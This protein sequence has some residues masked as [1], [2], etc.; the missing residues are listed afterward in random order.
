MK[1]NA[2]KLGVPFFVPPP[3]IILVMKITTFFILLAIMSASAGIKAQSI[4]LSERN[5]SLQRVLEKIRIQSGYDLVGDSKLIKAGKPVSI[6]LKNGNLQDALKL[7]FSNQEL[8]FEIENKTILVKGKESSFWEEIVARL[9]LIDI[10]SRI[11][12]DKGTVLPGATV[13]IKGTGRVTTTD[14]DGTFTLKGVD[15]H[16]ILSISFI[17]FTTLEIEAGKINGPVTLQYMVSKLDEVTVTTAYGIE[18]SKKELGYS[19]AKVSGADITKANSGSILMGLE[20]KVS[21]MNIMAQSSEMSPKMKILLRGIRSFGSSS[22]NQPLFIFNGAPLSFGSDGDAGEQALDFINNLNPADVEDVT[23]LKGANGA[24]MYGPEGVNGVIIITTK[25]VKQG[26]MSVNARVNT[27]YNRLDWRPRAEQHTFGVGDG[28]GNLGGRALDNWGPAYD[29]KL[30]SIGYP[31]KNGLYQQVPYTDRDDRHKFFNVGTTTRSNVSLAQG[32]PTGSYY[33]GLGYTTQTGL[34][35]GDKQD[36]VNVLYN[37][38]KRFGKIADVQLN[39]NF[40]KSSSDKGTDVTAAVVNMPSFIPLLSY[41][42]YQNSYWG[43]TDNYW[44]GRNPYAALGMERTIGRNIAFNGSLIATLKPTSWFNIKDQVSMLYAERNSKTN[45][46]PVVFSDFARVDPLKAYDIQPGTSDSFIAGT[47]VNNDILL[48]SVNKAG[49]FLIRGT[50]GNTIRN[51][52]TKQ[53]LTAAN[54]IIPVYNDIFA[55]KDEGVA[56]QEADVMQRTIS[57]FGNISVGYKDKIFLEVTGRDEWDS[58]RAKV[59]RGKDLYFGANSSFVMKELVPYLKDLDWLSNFRLRLSATKTAN[60]NIAPQQSELI[61]NLA[62]GYPYTNPTTG[63]SVLGYAVQV[64]PNP[65]LKPEKVFS[66]EY[67]TEIGLFNNRI[68]FDA[69]YYHQVNDGV[70]MEVG[71]PEWSAYPDIDNAGRFQNSGWEFDLNLS[72]LIDFGN[73]I[74]INLIG[75]LSINNNKVLQVSDIYNGTFIARDPNGGAEYYARVNHSAFEFP[76]IDWKRDPNGNVIVDKNSGMPTADTQNP[77]PMGRTLP[78]YQGGFTLNFNYKRFSLSTQ[79]DYSA[80]NDHLFDANAIS[81]GISGLTLLNNREVFIFP[82]SVIE[83]SPGHFVKN[84]G[85]AVSSAGKDLFSRFAAASINSV[86][87]ASYWKLREVSITYDLPLKTKWIKRCTASIYGRDLF[88]LYPRSNIY[89]DPVA[90]QGPGIKPATTVTGAGVSASSSSNV[91]GGSSDPNT[92]PGTVLYGFTL[93]V[94][95]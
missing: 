74:N 78:V 50:L 77:K 6:N 19:V 15:E 29:G 20:G 12:D 3:K 28:I 76:V 60:M 37:S 68:K 34:L 64:N 49:D 94:T 23:I 82:N 39:M 26:E 61:F 75:R 59:A 42:D 14:K 65:F 72:P 67:G 21:G 63:T 53:L 55:R 40:S 54:L 41:K 22:N 62:G 7:V 51:T 45:E 83:D 2:F 16:A 80:G 1:I 13:K 30:I 81:S 17:G 88:S 44:L 85:V 8:S 89:G 32:D 33:L 27:S 38:V 47:T 69:A 79:A 11:V 58:K 10:N 18:R 56:A 9:K 35:P 25:K 4:N 31:D 43:S 57:A 52:F 90:S 36:Q 92:I 86:S 70:I 87:S 91:A 95:F 73:G 48:S 46:E 24:A 93:G 71:V 84:T 66:Q 5:T